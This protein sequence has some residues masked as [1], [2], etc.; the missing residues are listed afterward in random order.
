MLDKIYNNQNEE[1]INAA[2]EEISSYKLKTVLAHLNMSTFDYDIR[3]D[4][5]Y[6]RKENMLLH[7]F[8]D[9]WF[10]DGGDF[11]YLEN[12]TERLQELVRESFVESTLQELKAVK[13]NESEYMVSFEAPI[14][15]KAGNTRWTSFAMDTV[16]DEEGRPLYAI[17]YCKDINEE[18][19]EL[20]RVRRLAQTDLL[21]G[22]R[23][24]ATGIYRIENNMR[25][26]AGELHFLAVLDLDKFKDANDL[27][28]HAFGDEILKNVADR[29]R[30]FD[31]HDRIC[32]RLGGDEFMVYGRCEDE[33]DA[34]HLM[35]ELKNLIRYTESSN[36]VEFEVDASIGFAIHPLQGVK[37]DELYNK[38]DI[39][40]YYAKRNKSD[41][42][43]LYEAD[44]PPIR[45]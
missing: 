7:D 38:A 1:A 44:M 12:V 28:G 39:A 22:L 41:G 33:E 18:R 27:F 14:I 23:N 4:V 45:R 34:M 43:I 29:I 5:V 8:T 26:D 10:A 16:A 21:T 13:E 30:K 3:K 2:I 15:Y 40:M 24:R 35:T 11:Y 31:K 17:G 9:H 6:V 20:Q 32:S 37:F 25:E 36:G 42:P 19:K